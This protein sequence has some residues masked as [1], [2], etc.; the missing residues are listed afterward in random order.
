MIKTLTFSLSFLLTL[1]GSYPAFALPE[2][3]LVPGG[4]ALLQL[5]AYKPDTKIYFAG[6]RVAVFPYTNMQGKSIW[7]A[8]AGIDLSSKPGDY[9]FS[10]QHAN[11]LNL[12]TK[13]TVKYKK[14]RRTAS[15]H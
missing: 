14:L 9:E 10:I 2:Q 5:P 12:N 15:H 13:V 7:Y 1:V 11:G 6:K 3:A 4:I 8:M